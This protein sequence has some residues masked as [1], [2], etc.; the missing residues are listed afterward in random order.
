MQTS[1]R[2]LT[3]INKIFNVIDSCKNLEHK[4]ITESWVTRLFLIK[5]ITYEEFKNLRE[6]L[7]RV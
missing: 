6:Y 2:V 7:W 4:N 3:M 1:K 5:K